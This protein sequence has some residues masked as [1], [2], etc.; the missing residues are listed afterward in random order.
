MFNCDKLC[1][2]LLLH[3]TL[4]CGDAAAKPRSHLPTGEASTQTITAAVAG[5]VKEGQVASRELDLKPGSGVGPEA[6]PL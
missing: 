6:S 3:N 4:S 5:A 1:H 2:P